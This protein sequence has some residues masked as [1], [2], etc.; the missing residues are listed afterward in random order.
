MIRLKQI[1]YFR[2]TGLILTAI[3]AVVSAI[4]F[5]PSSAAQTTPPLGL[6][7][8]TPEHKAFKNAQIVVSS[9]LTLDS[10]MMIIDEGKIVAIGKN[11]PLPADATVIDLTGK[12]IYPGF[13]D[14][15]T[16][17][18]MEKPEPRRSVNPDQSGGTQYLGNRV[19]GNAWNDAIHAE[20]NC[21][22]TFKPDAK[23]AKDYLQNGITVVQSARLDG[24]FRGRG[25]VTTLG[26]GL[27]NDLV[28]RPYSWHFLSFDKGS[29]KQEYPGSLMGT[30]ALIRQT[31]YDVDWYRLAHEAL[32]LNP[33][34][35]MPEFNAAIEA[36]ASL[37][38]EKT[39]FE[40]DDV[41]S[42]LRA[43]KISKE[44]GIPF[45]EVGRG[46]EYAWVKQVAATGATLILPVDFPKPPS[47]KTADDELDV[48]LGD[49]SPLGNGAVESQDSCRQQD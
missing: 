45:I 24:I 15:F 37:K 27:P 28:L 35:K 16:D 22:T 4:M 3:L 29:S 26:D 13:I 23:E 21:V 5:T 36:L 9:Q 43:D 44:F 6:R 8:K 46:T 2:N 17:Y 40:S 49:P 42:L 12:T 25:F 7:D 14:P 31:F 32:K 18:G 10:A 38:G 34:Q 19:G 41:L 33:D 48:T 11:L 47:V 20:R 1:E 39:I 30:I